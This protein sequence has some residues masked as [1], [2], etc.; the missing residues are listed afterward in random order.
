MLENPTLAYA[1]SELGREPVAW[2]ASLPKTQV[3]SDEV[4]LCH[5][6]PR[7]DMVYLLEDI[8]N[9]FPVVKTEEAI[10][11]ELAGVSYPIILCGHTHLPRVV[12]LSSGVVV[13]NPGSVGVPAYDDA[14]PN[15]HAMQN[16]SPFASYAIIEKRDD[17][18]RMEL[19][20]IPYEHS[21]AAEQARRLGRDDWAGWIATG[22]TAA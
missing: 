15:Y 13:V 5:G 12:R 1:V 18:W 7:S 2:L 14:L 4:F 22:R 16:Y 21:L 17:T 20:K 19:L 3:V 11:R 8:Y 6:S 10:L 9:G